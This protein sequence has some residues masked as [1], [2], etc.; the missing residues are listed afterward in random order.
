MFETMSLACEPDAVRRAR[1]ISSVGSPSTLLPA[2]LR[3]HP[4]EGGRR[5]RSVAALPLQPVARRRLGEL[6]KK[7]K[8]GR[9][10]GGREIVAALAERG[11]RRAPDFPSIDQAE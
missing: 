11:P 3:R 5:P 8:R 6:Q 2:P 7:G 4:R 9:S 10:P 1:S